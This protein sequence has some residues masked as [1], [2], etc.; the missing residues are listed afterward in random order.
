V[1]A[2]E[3][4]EVLLVAGSGQLW[5]PLAVLVDEDDALALMAP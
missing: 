4:A 2:T 1:P 5:T 3:G